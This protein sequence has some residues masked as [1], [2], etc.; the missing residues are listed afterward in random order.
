MGTPARQFLAM[1]DAIYAND[2]A[3]RPQLKFERVA[4]LNPKKN[5]GAAVAENRHLFLAKRDGKFV[6]RIAAFTNPAHDAHRNENAGFFGFFD[7]EA[8]TETGE[9][10]LTA[11]Q[12]WM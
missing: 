10:L 5:P 11:A 3:W 4:H 9:A 8:N 7:C 2:P 1:P 12:S 6:G